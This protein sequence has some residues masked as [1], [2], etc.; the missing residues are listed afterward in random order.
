MERTIL[1]KDKIAGYRSENTF[2]RPSK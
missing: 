2:A 1:L